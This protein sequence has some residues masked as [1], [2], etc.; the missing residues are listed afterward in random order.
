[1]KGKI[2]TMERN[3]K[4]LSKGQMVKVLVEEKDHIYVY[5][6]GAISKEPVGHWVDRDMVG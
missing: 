1:M 2:F 5:P 3:W 6:L 4:N